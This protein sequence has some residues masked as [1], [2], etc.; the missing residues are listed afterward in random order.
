MIYQPDSSGNLV[1]VALIVAGVACCAV[2][3]IVARRWLG[4]AD[5]TAQVVLAQ[6]AYPLSLA[7]FLLAAL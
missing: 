4:D 2:Y 5:S 7:V 3:T 6:E 1:G